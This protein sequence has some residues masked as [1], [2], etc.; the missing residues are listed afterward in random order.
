MIRG[1]NS[2]RAKASFILNV[3][4][5]V[6]ELLRRFSFGVLIFVSII[7]IIVGRSQNDFLTNLRTHI[8]DFLS[9]ILEIAVIPLDIA[10]KSEEAFS[11]Y[12]FV[13]SKNAKLEEDNKKLRIQVAKL[14]QMQKENENL[15]NL[16]N[17]IQDL[18]YKFITAK[19]VGNSSGPFT[20]SAIINA[21]ESDSV[22]K[23]QAVVNNGGL[24]GRVVEVGNNSSRVLLLT[25]INSKIPVISMD[26][27]ERSILAGN[28]TESTKL[29]YLPKESKI[30]DGEVVLTSGDG[31]VM[32]PGILVGRAYKLADGSFEV[33]PFVKWHNIEYVSILGLKK[34]D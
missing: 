4:R 23:G 14:Y 10:S 30:A 16:L 25:D 20:R 7:A 21:G 31:E 2:R 32:P 29:I 6:R 22:I 11:S 33:L 12:L 34:E 3:S 9:P 15:K 1:Y 13:H 28:N 5:P 19:I 17:Y 18:E 24:V 27:R 8:L 26:S